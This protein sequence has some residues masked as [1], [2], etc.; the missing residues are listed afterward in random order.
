MLFAPSYTILNDTFCGTD[1]D[2]YPSQIIFN[3]DCG[4]CD[5][6]RIGK[7]IEC[8]PFYALSARQTYHDKRLN[9]ACKIRHVLTD[10]LNNSVGAILERWYIYYKSVYNI[11]KT[12]QR[13]RRP[14]L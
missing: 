8:L 3:L 12:R 14:G 2:Y 1:C 5:V 10:W 7:G 13:T 9:V 11:Y 6:I 4:C